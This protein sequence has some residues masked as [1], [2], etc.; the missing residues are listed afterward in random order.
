MY[1][2]ETEGWLKHYDFILLD[3]LSLQLAL[4]FSYI[5]CGNGFNPYGN[6]LYR[7][8]AIFLVLA[9][10]I[11]IFSLDTLKSVIL[12]RISH[13]GP[14]R[15]YCRSSCS[16]VFIFDTGRRGVFKNGFACDDT[17]LYCYYICF[18]RIMEKVSEKTDGGRRQP[19]SF[20]RYNIGRC[21]GCYCQHKEKQLCQI[22]YCGRGDNRL[23][24]GWKEHRWSRSCDK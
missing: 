9:D 16:A 5:F 11:V 17:F 1:K 2:K 18:Q 10:A 7:N 15:A 19:F 21:G 3:M 13:N 24:Y 4:V 6:L 22:Y 12:Q 20:D 8:M 23:R 14:S